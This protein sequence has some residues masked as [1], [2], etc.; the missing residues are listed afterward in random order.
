MSPMPCL[1]WLAHD[2]ASETKNVGARI[3][4]VPVDR[5]ASRPKFT[6]RIPPT[7]CRKARAKE[8]GGLADR[9]QIRRYDV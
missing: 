5:V 4:P 3:H 7:E 9:Q 8:F 6:A 1:A 2:A